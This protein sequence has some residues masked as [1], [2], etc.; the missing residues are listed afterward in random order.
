M[1]AVPEAPARSRRAALPGPATALVLAPALAAWVLLAATA[2]LDPA[3]SLCLAPRPDQAAEAAAAIRLALAGLTPARVAEGALAMSAA[4][5]LPL[6]WLPARALAARSFRRHRAGLAALFGLGFAVTWAALLVP[7]S[8]AATLAQAGS[9]SVLGAPAAA[10]AMAL[11]VAAHRASPM[12]RRALSR[13]HR[14]EPV[15]AF[16]PAAQ[17]DAGGYGARA[18][19]R[20]AGFCWPAMLLPFFS[21]RPLMAMALVTVLAFA[22]RAAFRPS[23]RATIIALAALA[24]LELALPAA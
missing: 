12:A 1:T 20:C 19:C 7:L 13:C 24:A 3:A 23:P 9:A 22:D 15:R 4:M 16:A 21:S 17:L 2:R 18:A 10:A 5:A 14:A 8:A 6:A 11:A